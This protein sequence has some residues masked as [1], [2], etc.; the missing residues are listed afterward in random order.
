MSSGHW[1]LLRLYDDGLHSACYS[2][3]PHVGVTTRPGAEHESY[4]TLITFSSHSSRVVVCFPAS[5]LQVV[6]AQ[7]S[8]IPRM[9]FRLS[10]SSPDLSCVIGF[11]FTHR[12]THAYSFSGKHTLIHTYIFIFTVYTCRL[13]HR[14][15]MYSNTKTYKCKPTRST[16]IFTDTDT[17]AFQEKKSSYT[18]LSTNA[19]THLHMCVCVCLCKKKR[20]W[21]C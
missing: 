8:V 18:Q 19:H 21:A 14:I 7:V 6:A 5:V 17:P 10:N 15:Q 11:A 2:G 4:G 13:V 9:T 1:H 20:V 16:Y 12:H 3:V